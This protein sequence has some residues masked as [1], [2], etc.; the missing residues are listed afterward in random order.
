[1]NTEIIK[2]AAIVG[3]ATV[4]TGYT[5][6]GFYALTGFV[7]PAG[8][9]YFFAGLGAY[10]VVEGAEHYI[11]KKELLSENTHALPSRSR[12]KKKSRKARKS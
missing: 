4:V 12:R 3:A 9:F 11:F 6:Q 10:F 2:N 8:V 1:M 7:P 5:L